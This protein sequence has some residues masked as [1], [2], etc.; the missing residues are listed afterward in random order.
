MRDFL[1]RHIWEELEPTSPHSSWLLKKVLRV[2]PPDTEPERIQLLYQYY[3]GLGPVDHRGIDRYNAARAD[4]IAALVNPP[5]EVGPSISPSLYPVEQDISYWL[6]S[7]LLGL[8]DREIAVLAGIDQGTIEEPGIALLQI[9]ISAFRIMR[10]I[11]LKDEVLHYYHRARY[12]LLR[13]YLDAHYHV[14]N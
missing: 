2:E 10:S 11:R 13:Y 7:H 5:D 9:L 3:H 12:R 8:S 14:I 1:V 4:L 6:C